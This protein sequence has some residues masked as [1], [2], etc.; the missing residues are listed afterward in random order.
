MSDSACK[1]TLQLTNLS[2]NGMYGVKS[3]FSMV[4]F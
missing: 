3:Y 1:E 4:Q 2:N